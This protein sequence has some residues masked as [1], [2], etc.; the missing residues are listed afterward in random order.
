MT[1]RKSVVRT[2]VESE[3]FTLSDRESAAAAARTRPRQ[4][5]PDL[6]P[7]GYLDLA[8]AIGRISQKLGLKRSAAVELARQQLFGGHLPSHIID[9]DGRVSRVESRDWGSD[10]A[11][12]MIA[13]GRAYANSRTDSTILVLEDDLKR[14][15]AGVNPRSTVSAEKA[16][17]QKIAQMASNG[18][19]PRDKETLWLEV[20]K[21]LGSGLSRRGFDRAWANAAPP[22]WKKSG[23]KSKKESLRQSA[24]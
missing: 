17:A 14:I 19:A 24:Q 13:T 7:D 5:G 15:L 23:A 21:E 10:N 6:V 2:H 22:D 4:R 11:S 3:E 20:S 12:E 18:T 1:K 16:C 9:A 8:D